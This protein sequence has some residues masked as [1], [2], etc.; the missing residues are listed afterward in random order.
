MAARKKY[1]I[2]CDEC[3]LIKWTYH[4]DQRYCSQKCAGVKRRK[5]VTKI[6]KGC[7]K[8][9][10]IVQWKDYQG[11]CDRECYMRVH[12]NEER[13]EEIANSILALDEALKFCYDNEEMIIPVEEQDE[14]PTPE[15][16]E[17]E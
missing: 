5:Q 11:Y 9:F 17:S 13:R 10:T 15:T 6:C 2:Q 1:R 7:G 4:K 12:M 14:P 3:G 16:P 8:T